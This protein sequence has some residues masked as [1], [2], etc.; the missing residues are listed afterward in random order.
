MPLNV[1]DAVK[2]L[3]KHAEKAPT[4]HCATFV[5][6]ALEAG[7]LFINPHPVNACDYG[8]ALMGNGFEL[9]DMDK[10]VPEAGDV[11]VIQPYPSGTDKMGKKYKGSDSAGHIA[12]YD[13]R[14]WVSDFVQS[15]KSGMMGGPGY[16]KH[17]TSFAV[18]RP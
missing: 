13:G 6:E 8:P 2:Y 5:R 12:M 17:A 14:N 16:A 10:Y 15:G 9:V 4:K 18:Y 11:V 7:G 3:D 1:A